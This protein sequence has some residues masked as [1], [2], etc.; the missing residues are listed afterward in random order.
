MLR[1]QPDGEV[2]VTLPR[3]TF[4]SRLDLVPVLTTLGMPTAFGPDADFGGLTEDVALRLSAVAHQGHV[5]L[6]EDGVEATAATVVTAVP[7]SASAGA[8]REL[9]IDQ[10]FLFCIHD[11]ELALPLLVGV[12]NDRTVG[13]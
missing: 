11:V 6:D 5:A 8:D 1:S 2:S 13:S 10:P 4:G 7:V 9:I 12:V 3:F